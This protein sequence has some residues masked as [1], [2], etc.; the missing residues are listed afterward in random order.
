MWNIA[1]WRALLILPERCN[2]R[3]CVMAPPAGTLYAMCYHVLRCEA[4]QVDAANSPSDKS[5]K[6]E[7]RLRSL[8]KEELLHSCGLAHTQDRKR[9]WRRLLSLCPAF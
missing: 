3:F 7:N 5:L 8:R 4:Y 1:D 6:P 2:I 9:G